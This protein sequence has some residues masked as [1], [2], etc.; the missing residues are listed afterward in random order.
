[1]SFFGELKR[2]NV[3]RVCVAYAVVGWVIAQVAEFGFE[4]FGAPDWALRVLVILLLIG[5]PATGVIAWVFELTPDGI[6]RETDS[7]PVG[8]RRFSRKLDILIVGALSFAV[9]FL[10]AERF[11]RADAPLKSEQTTG[12]AE[13]VAS[14][15]SIAVLP[16]VNL[17]DDNDHFADGLTEELLN[18]LANVPGL[19][20]AGR[21]SSFAFKGRNVDLRE[22][23]AALNVRAVL[24]GSV[25]RSGERLRITAQLVDVADGFH[26]WSESYDRQMADIFDIQDDVASSIAGAL[27][28]RL[29]P[30]A[31]PPTGDPQAY[32]LYLEALAYREAEA[33]YKL[34]EALELLDRAIARDPGFAKAWELK[35]TFYWF[36][37]GTLISS[38]DGQEEAYTA[39]MRA[40]ELDPSLP[41]ARAFAT[42]ARPVN[43]TWS[44]EIQALEELNR[45][46][47]GNALALDALTYDLVTAGY[48]REAVRVADRLVEQDPLSASAHWRRAHALIAAG[49]PED[50]RAGLARSAELGNPVALLDLTRIETIA[51]NDP[52]A[53]SWLEKFFS[54]TDRNPEQAG[55][56]FASFRD[57]DRGKKNLDAWIAESITNAEILGQRIG[58]YGWYLAFGY[59]DDFWAA[60]D[61]LRGDRKGWSDGDLLE[62]LGQVYARSGFRRHPRYVEHARETTLTDLWD[63]RGAPDHCSKHS[64]VWTCD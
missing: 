16:F 41:G 10:L 19:K 14:M 17:S 43:W 36:L 46:Q 39:A 29:V 56:L 15:P 59:M 38:A 24:E 11:Y 50:A 44:A 62:Y 47:P 13:I 30:A 51:G 54:A 23:G 32:A 7:P 4:I 42:T 53:I 1:M 35:A 2:R 3:A 31:G 45:T 63:R 33:T 57:P 49:R 6:V 28:L 64:D 9:V 48:A 12:D 21:T 52:S 34:T 18:L 60:L 5:L 20:V 40:L 37:T 55:S 26:L 61:E 22:I 27:E 8:P 58:A 25:R